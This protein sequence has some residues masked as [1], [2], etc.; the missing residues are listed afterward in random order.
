V[1]KTGWFRR[2]IFAGICFLLVLCGYC[3]VYF[4]PFQVGSDKSVL[5]EAGKPL[6][7]IADKLEAEGIVRSSGV[8]SLV[9][10]VRGLGTQLQAGEYVFSGRVSMRDVVEKLRRGDVY[11]HAVT[12]PEGLTS[13]QIIALLQDLPIL[14]GDVREIP[15]EGSL[16]PETYHVPRGSDRGAVVRDMQIAMRRYLETVW[17]KRS[18]DVP[19]NTPDEA[20]ILASIVEKETGIEAER[21]LVA[22]VFINRL[23]A[24]MRLQSDPTIIYG[25]TGGQKAL[26]RPI[27]RSEIARETPYNTYVIKGLPPAP[28]ANPGRAAIDAVLN[29]P[30]TDYLFFV[31]DGSGGHVFAKTLEAHNANVRRWRSNR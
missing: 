14:S 10:R 4:I 11:L 29:P 26:G 1:I 25:L 21:G 12:I 23:R 31:A 30:Q 28:I 3:S 18:P 20:I 24:K 16:L 7:V 22:S 5:V 15:A 13:Y 2:A 9:T 17:A 8:F 27:R 19:L 6:R